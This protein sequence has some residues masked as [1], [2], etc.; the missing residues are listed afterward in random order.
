MA[1]SMVTSRSENPS[2]VGLMAM[3][4]G[5]MARWSSV[6]DTFSDSGLK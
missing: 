6:K 3:G 2:S 4:K 5:D 1:L